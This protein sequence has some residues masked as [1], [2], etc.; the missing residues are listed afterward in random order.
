VVNSEK[1]GVMYKHILIPT[2]GSALSASA[3]EQAIGLAKSL[4]AKVTGM[5]VSIPFHTFALDPSMVSDTAVQY[6]KH[7]EERAE[8]SLGAIRVAAKAAGVQCEVAHVTA[9]QPYEGIIDTATSK[10]C[11]LIFMASHG[12][13]GVSAL[14]LGSETQKVLTHSKIPVLV[15]R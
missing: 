7:C 6:K 14:V 3:I 1:E 9:D 12:R 10:G 11:D 15:S 5:T 13:K 8:K 4:G 2:D